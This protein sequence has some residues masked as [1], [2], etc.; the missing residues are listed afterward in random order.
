[1]RWYIPLVCILLLTVPAAAQLERVGN[2]FNATMEYMPLWFVFH[3]GA[4]YTIINCTLTPWV[5]LTDNNS[6]MVLGSNDGLVVTVLDTRINVT[7]LLLG[8][9]TSYNLTTTGDY[10][11][12]YIYFFTGFNT[13]GEKI[14]VHLYTSDFEPAP[15]ETQDR[16]TY[17]FANPNPGGVAPP[18]EPGIVIIGVGAAV[19]L[20][21]VR[22]G[23]TAKGGLERAIK[24][25]MREHPWASRKTA[26]RIAKDHRKG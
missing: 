12:Y 18:V 3:Y 11:Y 21:A 15:L 2:G 17:L 25:E 13:T 9:T 24:K 7:P 20:M 23:R 19:T 4:Q 22:K 16:R 14:E 8:T 26:E 5:D 10:S 6:W 1:M